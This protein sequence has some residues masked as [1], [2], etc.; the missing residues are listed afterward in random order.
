MS[1]FLITTKDNPYSPVDEYRQ[2]QVFDESH[3]YHSSSLLARIL[4]TS[5]ELSQK[6]QE[7][8]VESAIDE[9]I[10]NDLFD[11]YKKIKV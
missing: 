6:N 9:I 11:I 5:T 1:E 7:F 8:D 10:E 4:N 3:G 2:W